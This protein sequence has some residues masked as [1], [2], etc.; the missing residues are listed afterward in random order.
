MV[1]KKIA[2]F[3]GG[4]SSEHEVSLNSAKTIYQKIDK[5]KYELYFFYISKKVLCKLLIAN[6]DI[7]FKKITTS[8]PLVQGLKDLKHKKIFAFLAG[9]HGEF[10]ED[11]RLQALLELYKI[12]YTGSGVS[13]SSIAMDKYR[14]ALLVSTIEGV[15]LPKTIL[16]QTPY[17]LPKSLSLPVVIKPNALGSSVSVTIAHTSKD[18]SRQIKNLLKNY[19]KQEIIVQEYIEN[20]IEIQSGTLQKKDGTF[21]D[22]PPIEIIPKKNIFFDYDSKYLVG[23][24]TE[25]TPPVGVPKELSQKIMKISIKLHKLLGLRTYSRNDFLVK[26]GKIYF[27]EANTL[28]GMTSTSLLPQEAQA[29]GI[30]FP[31]LLDFIINNS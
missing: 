3:C 4:P 1:K 28:P 30:S 16:L 5:E 17:A 7:Q 31:E 21:I 25:I 19:P 8:I 6:N 24:A 18:F 23:G 20:A 9:I 29:I 12:P 11:G 27:L 13:G 10:V 26:D 15:N 14:A 2:I 22:V